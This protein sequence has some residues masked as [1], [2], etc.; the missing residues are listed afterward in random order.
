MRNELAENFVDKVVAEKYWEFSME[1]DQVQYGI[2]S[3]SSLATLQFTRDDVAKV[4]GAPRKVKINFTEGGMDTGYCMISSA[5]IQWAKDEGHE[6]DWTSLMPMG[7]GGNAAV[8]LDFPMVLITGLEDTP[9]I[10]VPSA[11]FIR[12]TTFNMDAGG[13]IMWHVDQWSDLGGQQ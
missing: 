12:A 13:L 4:N 11:M 9:F 3:G 10:A 2:I 6:G 7:M 8:K 5:P 1:V